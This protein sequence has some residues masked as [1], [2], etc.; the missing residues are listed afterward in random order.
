MREVRPERIFSF[1]RAGICLI[2]PGPKVNGSENGMQTIAN[3]PERTLACL[4]PEFADSK[5]VSEFG[6]MVDSH[7]WKFVD[8]EDLGSIGIMIRYSC[9]KC[10]IE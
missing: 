6:R 4:E 7:N 9:S 2:L 3:P 5:V 10:G 8:F 1:D